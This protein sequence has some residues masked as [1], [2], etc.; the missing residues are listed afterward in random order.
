MRS[1]SQGRVRS[2]TEGTD[3]RQQK[4]ILASFLGNYPT[5]TALAG[6]NHRGLAPAEPPP[7]PTSC[8]LS[9]CADA[10]A[11]EI[12]RRDVSSHEPLPPQT[13]IPDT[14]APIH[15]HWNSPQ[16]ISRQ[17]SASVNHLE[18]VETGREL[19]GHGLGAVSL[20]RRRRHDTDPPL[21]EHASLSN[22]SLNQKSA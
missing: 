17:A 4:H 21:R 18:G 20:E 2:W 14:L 15:L 22:L 11:S 12:H 3:V 9:R 7:P 19:R 13:L 16:P 6:L 1:N 10:S 5:F 8:I